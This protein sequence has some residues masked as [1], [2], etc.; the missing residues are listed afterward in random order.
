MQN[1]KYFF[2]QRKYFFFTLVNVKKIL[3]L[4]QNIFLWK[5]LFDHNI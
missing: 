4:R 5:P 3:H 2:I 1:Y